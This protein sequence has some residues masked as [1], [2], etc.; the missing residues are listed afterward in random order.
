MSVFQNDSVLG[1]NTLGHMQTL[2]GGNAVLCSKI[3][4][5]IL[6]SRE[7]KFLKD[8]TNHQNDK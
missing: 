7:I 4:R 8:H 3:H 5:Y 2:H 6:K 1:E